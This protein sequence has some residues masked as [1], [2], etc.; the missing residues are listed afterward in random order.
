MAVIGNEFG[1]QSLLAII[2]ALQRRENRRHARAAV[3][4]RYPDLVHVHLLRVFSPLKRVGAP[5]YFSPLKPKPRLTDRCRIMNSR[6]TG[7]VASTAIAICSVA[8]LPYSSPN[9]TRPSG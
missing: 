5:G 4:H 6:N 7:S 8:G 9:C 2:A 3:R 1:I